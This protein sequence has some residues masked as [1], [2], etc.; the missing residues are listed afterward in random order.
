MWS[1]YWNSVVLVLPDPCD[2]MVVGLTYCSHAVPVNASLASILYFISV[3]HQ[4][5]PLSYFEHRKLHRSHSW[6]PIQVRV[7]IAGGWHCFPG[8]YTI[9][10][11]YRRLQEDCFFRSRQYPSRRS[12]RKWRECHEEVWLRRHESAYFR[13]VSGIHMY[14]LA[15]TLNHC[16]WAGFRCR[17]PRCLPIGT[18]E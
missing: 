2:Q 12:N 17:D 13:P 9:R 14:Q 8:A 5:Q 7:T 18:G 15:T 6:L 1:T 3:L 11:V 16:V 4:L 10:R